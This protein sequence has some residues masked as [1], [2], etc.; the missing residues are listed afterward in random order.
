MVCCDNIKIS[1]TDNEE[2]VSMGFYTRQP[3]KYNDR[4]VYAKGSTYLYWET[5][6]RR[7]AVSTQI[8][9]DNIVLV[10]NSQNRILVTGVM[11]LR[12]LDPVLE[13]LI[14]TRF[15]ILVKIQVSY[16]QQGAIQIGYSP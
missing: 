11:I 1:S 12:R 14:P 3:N 10:Y 4:V 13:L 2:H 7:W 16:A 9:V 5:T 15:I 8:L 6:H